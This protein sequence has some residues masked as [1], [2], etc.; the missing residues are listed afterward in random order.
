MSH[1]LAAATSEPWVCDAAKEQLKASIAPST[2]PAS[3]PAH[4]SPVHHSPASTPRPALQSA[5]AAASASADDSRQKHYNLLRE[6]ASCVTSNF[7]LPVF[8]HR[9]V[10]L[11]FRFRV[12]PV[13][14]KVWVGRSPT[15]C[16]TRV[17][18]A[19]L[20]QK[21]NSEREEQLTQFT[22]NERRKSQGKYGAQSN[23]DTVAARA[24][25]GLAPD[26]PAKNKGS[27]PTLTG[28]LALRLKQEVIK[29]GA[30]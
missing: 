22:A 1:T 13:H 7:T 8:L 20:R 28:A 5:S 25:K 30:K 11:F 14:T 3:S 27:A 17:L 19:G 15:F 16:P 23:S 10:I 2:G 18:P 9:P 12:R 24:P 4:Q 21:H 6:R 26:P 29:K